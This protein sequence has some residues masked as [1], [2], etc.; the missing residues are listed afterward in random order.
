MTQYHN[1]GLGSEAYVKA[2]NYLKKENLVSKVTS[3]TMSINKSM[4]KLLK[5]VGMK[6]DG[7]R[8]NHYIF[9]KK[10]VDLVYYSLYL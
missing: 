6:K 1:K 3:G 5:K 4:I 7:I 2:I 9:S 10:R 8:K